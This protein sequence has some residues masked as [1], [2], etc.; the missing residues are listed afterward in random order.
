MLSE[1]VNSAMKKAAAKRGVDR[2]LRA[3]SKRYKLSDIASLV[4]EYMKRE[5]SWDTIISHLDEL[6]SNGILWEV[7]ERG[8]NNERYF[9]L[10]KIKK[11]K[12]RPRS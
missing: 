6:V 12:P 5:V 10:S 8:M 9:I 7:P 3:K 11:P 2:P 1:F 4:R